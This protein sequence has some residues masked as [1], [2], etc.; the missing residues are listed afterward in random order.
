MVMQ[1][2]LIV[3]VVVALSLFGLFLHYDESVHEGNQVLG[4]LSIFTA[5]L[6]R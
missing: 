6:G 3:V 4:S 2:K 1:I 5:L